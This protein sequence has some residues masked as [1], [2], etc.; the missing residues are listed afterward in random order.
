MN[1]QTAYRR[2]LHLWIGALF[3]LPAFISVAYAEV[4]ADDPV[5]ADVVRMLDAGLEPRVIRSWLDHGRNQPSTLSANDMI[6]LAAAN[7]PAELIEDL[8]Q[9]STRAGGPAVAPE[10]APPDAGTKKTDDPAPTG[11]EPGA[12]DCCLVEFLVEYRAPEQD[13]AEQ[14]DAPRSD[15]Y[16]YIDG[17]FLG[18]F[19]PREEIA[20]RGPQTFKH[21]IEPGRHTIRLTRELHLPSKNRNA[22]DAR[23]HFT[24]VS[25]S[26]IEFE[27]QPGAQWTM[28][29]R[30][31]QGVFSRK[32][33][34][35]WRWSKNGLPVAGEEQAGAYQEDWPYLCDD[36]EISRD[37][38]AIAE[39]RAN[40][41][42]ENCITWASLW[43]QGVDTGRAQILSAFETADFRP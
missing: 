22:G 4:K 16:L 33:P 9:R 30:W 38:G 17:R 3:L 1:L 27:L 31:A 28:D 20:G 23:D 21:R 40:D 37:S 29:I 39:W 14:G 43:P 13:A 24:T 11:V 2:R 7:A 25:P 10:G 34:L 6:A 15:L 18:R 35:R 36:V 19:A 26:S 12:D 32:Q 8:L 42:S 5:V 41:R